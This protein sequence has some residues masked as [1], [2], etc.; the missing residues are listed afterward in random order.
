MTSSLI[1][2]RLFLTTIGAASAVGIGFVRPVRPRAQSRA[3][4]PV[5]IANASGI[6][7]LI[8]GELMR[9]QQF[10]EHFDL[11]ATVV[12]VSDGNKI[13]SSIIGGE[14]DITAM[15][16]FGQ[17]FPAMERGGKLKVL[18]G[19]CILPTLAA[20]TAKAEIRTLQDL[21]GKTIGSGA[22]GSLVHQLML[23]LLRKKGVDTSGIRFVNIGASPDI[24]RAVSVGTVDAGLGEST[25][26]LNPAK[27]VRMLPSSNL[28]DELPEYTYQGAYTSQAMI[29]SKRE[30][31]VRA[32]AAYGMLYRF[33]QT[34]EA[35]DAFIKARSAI[36][37]NG[38]MEEHV[39]IWN[40][41]QEKQPFA[42]DLTLNDERLRYM[43]S[44]NL[45]L[46]VQKT[47]L[48]FSQTADMS[49]AQDAV[50]LLG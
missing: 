15:S 20:Y 28:A 8:M 29:A 40:F 38:S 6:N 24:F 25:L 5:T 42:K 1:N 2:R 7:T 18:A 39:L 19:A 49:L 45:D 33:V 11:A 46:K 21:A 37:K 30:V 34:P 10:F 48:P 17:I 43:Q 44:L 12:H 36:V 50:K 13:T 16:G 23:A 14:T 47:Q 27:P 3:K 35:R 22:T 32:L 4:T 26:L 31:L 41:I 9:Q